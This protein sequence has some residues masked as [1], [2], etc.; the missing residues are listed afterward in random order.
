MTINETVLEMHFHKPIMD[1]FRQVYGVGKSGQVKFYKYS[2]QKEVFIGFDQAYAMTELSDNDFF[3]M[4]KQSSMNNRY[5]L[6]KKFI[7]YFLQFKVVRQMYNLQKNT[8]KGITNKPHYRVKLDTQK[9]QNTGFSQHEL[10]FD[11]NKNV[12]AMVFYACPMIFDKS[13]LYEIDVDLNTLQLADLDTCPSKYS[14]NETH[15]IYFNSPT[16]TPIWCSKPVDGKSIFPKE[17]VQLIQSKVRQIDSRESAKDTIRILEYLKELTLEE[18]R[19]S[20]DGISFENS[21]SLVH[22]SL[23]IM[24]VSGD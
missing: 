11:L 15:Y 22:D 8:P 6:P 17:F 24:E 5:V 14:D 19:K 4:L 1:L 16:A 3:Q 18:P 21:I 13:A 12:G 2:P 10:L 23:T 9:N 20:I 7:A